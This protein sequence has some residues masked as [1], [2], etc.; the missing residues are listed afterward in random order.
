MNEKEQNQSFFRRNKDAI[1]GGVIGAGVGLFAKQ[2]SNMRLLGNVES[3]LKKN[4][5]TVEQHK[6][7]KDIS[8][9]FKIHNRSASDAFLPNKEVL[10]KAWELVENEGFGKRSIFSPY[11]IPAATALG[12]VIGSGQDKTRRK[13][14][15]LEKQ[16][17]ELKAEEISR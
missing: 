7:L 13:I 11:I 1:M 3:W 9:E 2:L 8:N 14:E 16:V 12:A 6:L 17:K 5:K 15:S 10:S 4:A